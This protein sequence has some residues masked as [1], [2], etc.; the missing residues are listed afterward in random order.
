MDRYDLAEEEIND[1]LALVESEKLVSMLNRV[2]RRL[3]EIKYDEILLMASEYIYQE[4]YEE[5]FTNFNE[6]IRLIPE[7]DT[8]YNQ[9][10]ELYILLKDYD[11]AK[12]LLGISKK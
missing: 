7:I 2:E 12:S 9:M 10:A 8:A 1:S 6:A 4:N 3:K 5:A 11:T